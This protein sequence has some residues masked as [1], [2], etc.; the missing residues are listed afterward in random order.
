MVKE[1]QK[2]I[3]IMRPEAPAEVGFCSEV[4]FCPEAGFSSGI[5]ALEHTLEVLSRVEPVGQVRHFAGSAAEQELQLL[6]A[7]H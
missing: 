5:T 1:P 4:E 3:C 7:V 6:E 2:A